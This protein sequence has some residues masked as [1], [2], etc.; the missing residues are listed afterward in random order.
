MRIVSLLGVLILCACGSAPSSDLDGGSDP[1]D[2]GGLGD[3]G[4]GDS[5]MPDA[6]PGDSGT[7]DSG[8]PMVDPP[9]ITAASLVTHGTH[10][11]TW[12]LPASGCSSV[13]LAM[14]VGSP[15]TY[16]NVKTLAGAATSTQYS[17][18]HA[19]GTYCY[20]VTCALNG[21]TSVNSNEKCVT[22]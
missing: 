15:G 16:S 21:T 2:A 8:T 14:K 12:Q 22:Q 10:Q 19:N 5:G 1:V 7:P 6:G 18:G 13:T 20:E 17:P 11:I 4:P 3:A 9:V